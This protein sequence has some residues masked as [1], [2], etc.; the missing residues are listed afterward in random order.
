MHYFKHHFIH[1]TNPFVQLLSGSKQK[2]N[3]LLTI[4]LRVF[5]PCKYLYVASSYFDIVFSYLQYINAKIIT[6]YAFGN[7][8]CLC[9]LCHWPIV[10]HDATFIAYLF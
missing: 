3:S 5:I 10:G 6:S 9:S 7:N 8:E 4:S 1:S 2:K